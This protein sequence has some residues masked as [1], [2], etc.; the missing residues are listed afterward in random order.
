MDSTLN[1]IS[2]IDGRYRGATEKLSAYFSE[3][4]IIKYRVHVEVEY[5]IALSE[6]PLPGM[7]GF[8]A[9]NAAKLRKKSLP[10]Q[11]KTHAG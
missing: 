10:S 8:T 2:P 5:L 9:R 11:K 6:I 4:A 7:K 3:A 1:A